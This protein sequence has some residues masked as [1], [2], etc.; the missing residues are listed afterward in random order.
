MTQILLERNPQL[1]RVQRMK[2]NPMTCEE[3]VDSLQAS[4]DDELTS[5]DRLRAQKHLTSRDKCSAYLRGYE[6]TIELAKKTGSNIAGSAS[7]LKIWFVRSLL[8]G[9]DRSSAHGSWF[10]VADAEP[11]SCFRF[12]QKRT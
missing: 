2:K 4:L 3:F 10:S 8:G 1:G 7:C 9:A 6:W 12:G 5:P 11:S